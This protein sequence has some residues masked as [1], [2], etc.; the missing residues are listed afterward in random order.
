MQILRSPGGAVTNWQRL[1]VGTWSSAAPN[2]TS[3]IVRTARE[4]EV[5]GPTESCADWLL[6]VKPEGSGRAERDV[7]WAVRPAGVISFHPVLMLRRGHA[8]NP[9][10]RLDREGFVGLGPTVRSRR[11]G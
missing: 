10:G 7:F 2:G 9:T 1:L 4:P 3:A 6:S 11:V 8:P 5:M